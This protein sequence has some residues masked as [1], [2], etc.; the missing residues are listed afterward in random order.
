VDWTV[1]WADRNPP[2]DGKSPLSMEQA[3]TTALMN[4]R[5]LRSQVEQIAAGR[6]DLVQAGLLPN[7]VLAL[8]LR[9]P[10]DP[11]AGYSQVGATVVQ[12]LVSLW[13]RP[14][15]IRAADA[16]LNETV[17]SVSDSALRL[18]AD[19]KASHARVVFGQRAV[20]A[21][22]ENIAMVELLGCGAQDR[23]RGG[24]GTPLDPNRAQAATPVAASGSG[25]AGAGTGQGAA[26]AAAA[27][28]ARGR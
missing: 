8:A 20:A 27:H 10:V 26:E 17:L 11:V 12:D 24:E 13:L 9:F 7:P 18:V 28:R 23:V 3:A 21:T 6:A 1:P 4:N 16:R 22:R 19:V 15:R 25:V 5:A 14:G 2:W